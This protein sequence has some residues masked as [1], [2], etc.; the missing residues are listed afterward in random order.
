[1]CN[2][3]TATAPDSK[4]YTM[5]SDSQIKNILAIL[6]AT[7]IVDCLTC[8]S[9][10]KKVTHT[11]SVHNNNGTVFSNKDNALSYINV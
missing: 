9:N 2:T 7:M 4:R 8:F 11:H 1:M 10:R 6:I 5:T 3:P